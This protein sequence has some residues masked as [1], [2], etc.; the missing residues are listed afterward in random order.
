MTIKQGP[1]QETERALYQR[2]VARAE[3]SPPRLR[4][5]VMAFV[6][7]GLVCVLGEGLTDFW[8]AVLG[9][10]HKDAANPTVATLIF[11]SSLLTGLGLFDK[12]ARHAGAGLA[13]PVTGFANAM[14]ASA[15]EFKRE[16]LVFGVGGR[17]FQLAGAVIV[18]GVVTAFAVSI[19]AGLLR[20]GR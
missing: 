14:T 19:V 13:V 7:G 18:F 20:L 4:N 3:P 2:M 10:S 17:M 15:L 11:L 12:L 16:G 9:I 1:S 8:E 5:A 6:S